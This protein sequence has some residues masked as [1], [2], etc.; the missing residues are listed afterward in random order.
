MRCHTRN[1]ACRVGAGLLTGLLG[2]AAGPAAATCA[3]P[4]NPIK[5]ALTDLN[6]ETEAQR[7]VATAT[8]TSWNRVDDAGGGAFIATLSVPQQNFVFRVNEMVVAADGRGDGTL[9][10]HQP[11]VDIL[12]QYAHEEVAVQGSG[13]TETVSGQ[14]SNIAARLGALRGGASGFSIAGLSV[15]SEGR[16]LAAVQ[17][18][19]AAGD[20]GPSRLGGFVNGMVATGERDRTSREDGFDFD[21]IGVTAGLDY[22]FTDQWVAGVALGYSSSEADIERD[23]GSLD[24]DGYSLALYGLWY[25][26]PVHVEGS[27]SYGQNDYESERIIDYVNGLALPN[28]F[29]AKGDTDGSQITATLEVGYEQARGP[30]TLDYAARLA[31]L[32]ADVDGFT[33]TDAGALA[34]RVDDQDIRSLSSAL[35]V[36]AAYAMSRDF[37][38]LVPQFRAFWHHEFRDDSRDVRA[39]FVNDPFGTPFTIPTDDPDRNYF[40]LGVGLSAVLPRGFQGFVDYET[41]L[42]LEDVTYH[43]VTAG[44]RGEF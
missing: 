31:Y 2:I 7:N 17:R 23:G 29:N 18:G 10:G 6:H 34:L 30:W 42:G 25:R 21:S 43:A 27:L 4:A 24:T 36:R 22:R 32:D 8:Q 1:T 16:E 12:Q 3:F 11:L 26:G 38:V 19:G 44:V 5:C 20:Q 9:D 28:R 14:L 39:V 35:G 37:G 13:L 41:R 15:M 40:S 33:E